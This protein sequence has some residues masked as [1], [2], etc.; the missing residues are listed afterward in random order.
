MH[1]S[2]EKYGCLFFDT[3]AEYYTRNQNYKPLAVEIGFGLDKTLEHK[4]LSVGFDYKGVD[5]I[6]TDN[7]DDVYRLPFENGTVDVVV[8]SS[9]F[10]HDCFFWITFLEIMRVLKPNGTFYLN[11]PSRGGYHCH[12][13]DC[14]RFFPDAGLALTKWGR[15][16]NM[17]VHLLESFTDTS[18]SW[19]DYVAVFLRDE[20]FRLG[21]KTKMLDSVKDV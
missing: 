12:P 13:I 5:E 20:E 17:K 11:A 1:V 7:P 9:C 10:E 14:F 6:H 21:F 3:Y 19:N 4:A 15:K 16:N 2:A 8:S 18:E